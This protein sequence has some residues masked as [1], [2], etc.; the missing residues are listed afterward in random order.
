MRIEEK[1][2]GATILHPILNLDHLNV[3]SFYVS[4]SLLSYLELK[5]DLGLGLG[6]NVYFISPCCSII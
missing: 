2:Y 1:R 5:H 6:I 3:G 4:L